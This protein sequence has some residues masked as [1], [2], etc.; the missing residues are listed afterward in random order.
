ME[1]LFQEEMSEQEFQFCKEQLKTNVKIYLDMD[2]QIKALNKAI[3]E[4][5]KKKN[6]LSQEILLTM[7]K[8]EIDNMNTK[9][10]K[11]IYSTTKSSKPLNK[12]NL[13]TGLNLYF[14][15]EDKAK[16]VSKIVLDHRDKVETV[17]LRRTINKKAINNL[18]LQ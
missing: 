8:F 9:N 2:D 3:V 15:D 10:G 4:R 5:R 7:K 1:G 16:N 11:L 13:I 6:E 18:S 12:T 17:K 14:Q